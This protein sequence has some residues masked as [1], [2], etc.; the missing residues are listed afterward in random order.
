[1]RHTKDFRGD[2]FAV[3]TDGYIFINA[4]KCREDRIF[5]KASEIKAARDIDTSAPTVA[6]R[7]RGISGN[8]YDI[9]SMYPTFPRVFFWPLRGESER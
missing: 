3:D 9:S 4:V 5:E 2:F 1:M 8:C 7:F 6:A